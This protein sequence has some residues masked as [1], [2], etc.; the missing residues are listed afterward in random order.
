MQIAPILY[1]REPFLQGSLEHLCVSISTTVLYR[2]A[3][4]VFDAPL[5]AGVLADLMAIGALPT[6][7][8]WWV[9]EFLTDY[10]GWGRPGGKYVI[11]NRVDAY[12]N[13][14]NYRLLAPN[15]S[16]A[17]TG[18][19]FYRVIYSKGGNVGRMNCNNDSNGTVGSSYLSAQR[20]CVS[21]WFHKFMKV[22]ADNDTVL[23]Y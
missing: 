4:T 14:P 5:L 13:P 10:A 9:Q 21:Q 23:A 12:L 18:N 20:N 7:S 16:V 8:T 1:H 19:Q 6:I 11:W 15:S 22:I 2:L 17:H 3:L